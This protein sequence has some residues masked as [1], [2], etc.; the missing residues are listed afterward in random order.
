[1]VNKVRV[2]G[3]AQNRTALGIMHAYLVMNPKAT[4]DD[5]KKAFPDSLNPDSGVKI[6]FVNLKDVKKAQPEKWNGFFTD[7]ECLLNLAD[8]T[9]VAVVSMWTKPSFE[10]LVAKA[11]NYGI[12]IASFEAAEKGIGKKGGYRLEYLNGYVPPVAASG[13]K[14][15][16]WWLW[17]IL[18]IIII[19]ILALLMRGCRK[20]PEPVVIIQKDTV[21]QTVV[22]TDT[23]VI[24]K[25]IEKEA[26]EQSFNSEAAQFAQGSY[27]L[28]RTAK[29]VLN[30]LVSYLQKYEDVKL[31]VVGHTSAEGT[32]SYNQKLSE[33]RAKSVVDY[34][35]NCGIESSRLSYEG[36]GSSEQIDPD[37]P[38]LNRRTE[39]IIE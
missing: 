31:R 1:M 25:E 14:G 24:I 12:E 28:N 18:A 5:F 23:V 10:R 29:M 8:G 35:V 26:I 38:E 11:A 17:V 16:K 32:A 39:F 37:K 13:K 33:N 4:L 15:P 30:D 21:V 19:I 36:K 34:L 22:K 27:E 3:K 6:N 20:D 7:P 9:Q 2:Y